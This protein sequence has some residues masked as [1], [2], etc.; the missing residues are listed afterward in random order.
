MKI[1]NTSSPSS[2][3]KDFAPAY[4]DLLQKILVFNP[5]KRITIQ[6]ILE[7]EVVKEFHKPEQEV[8]CEKEISTSIDDNKKVTVD[9]YRRLVYGINTV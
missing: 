8:C 2:Y 3:L 4:V 6:E 5:K 9:E 1:S 7:H